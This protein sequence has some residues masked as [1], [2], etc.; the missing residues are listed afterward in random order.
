MLQSLLDYRRTV[1]FGLPM[2]SS[3]ATLFTVS[4]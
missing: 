2:A 4:I 1:R 3:S